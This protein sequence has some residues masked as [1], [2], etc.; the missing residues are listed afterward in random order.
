MVE[1]T[2]SPFSNPDYRDDPYPWF[3]QMR[4]ES[5]A[6]RTTMPSGAVVYV[7]TR[8]ADVLAAL[9]DERLVKDIANARPRQAREVKPAT[10]SMLK[11]DPPEHTRLRSLAQA[12]FTPRVISQWRDHIEEITGSLIDAIAPRGRMDLINDFALPLPITVITEMLGVPAA[13]QVKFHEWS[14]A[15]IASGVLNSEEPKDVPG[16]LPMAQYFYNLVAERRRSP[17]GDLVSRFIQAEEGGDRFSDGEVV[18]TSVLLLI[19]GHET[20][21]NLIG[22]GM[23]ALLQ[24]PQQFEAFKQEP[25]LI[26]PAIEELLRYVNP[27]Q[28]TNRYAAVDLEIG[29]VQI[30]RGSHVVL[31]FA[32][33]N[34]DPAFVA[35]PD[36]LD[37]TRG[38]TKHMAFG[39]GI[40]YCLGAPL[41]RLEGEIAFTR[42]IERFPNMRLADP[43]QKLVWRPAF[44]LRGLSALPVVF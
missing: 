15:V 12:A 7:V 5:P 17:Q 3:A 41:A 37:V 13:D 39:Q 32:A 4:S 10:Q 43:A 29:G 34:H 14:S 2:I 25:A 21:V 42:L 22:N 38:E 8:Y 33:A 35:K 28:A 6:Y 44:E 24:S 20:T 26:K 19:A 16:Y 30:P 9:K 1:T 40:H 31:T 18:A 27:A 23:L 11:A 36:H